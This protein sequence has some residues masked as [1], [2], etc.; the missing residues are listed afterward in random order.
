MKKN[1]ENEM[2]LDFKLKKTNKMTH[3]YEKRNYLGPD[4]SSKVLFLR[5]FKVLS[6]T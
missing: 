2:F 6:R 4:K 5:T 1:Y 3:Y